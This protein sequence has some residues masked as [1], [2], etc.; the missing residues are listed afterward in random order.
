MDDAV[1]NKVL[2]MAPYGLFLVG[3]RAGEER[4][5]MTG[6]LFMQVS[7]APV[8]VAVAV[9]NGAVTRRL[10][11]AGRVFSVNWWA[12]EETR[13]FVKFSRPAT[14]EGAALN[15]WAFH[16]GVTGAPIFDDAV[17][18]VDCTVNASH[19]AGTHTVFYGE[20]RDAG[21]QHPDVALARMEDTRMKYGGVA[22]H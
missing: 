16:D 14:Q 12:R 15:G 3:S 5:G 10:I 20:V 9:E 6:S 2:W 22:R 8:T 17:S 18:Y 11:D 1:L 13:V 21:I 19:D 7:F 4:N